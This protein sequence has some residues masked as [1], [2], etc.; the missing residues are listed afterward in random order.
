MS[1]RHPFSSRY[2]EEILRISYLGR[3]LDASGYPQTSP[4]CLVLD[5]R[6]EEFRVLRCEFKYIPSGKGDFERCGQFH[7]AVLCRIPSTTTKEELEKELLAQNGCHETVVLSE[8]KALSELPKY[9]KPEPEE[10]SKVDELRSI[11]LK[12]EY[13][14]VFAA[15]IAASIHPGTFHIDVMVD[16][17]S[18][19]F[20]QVKRM[21]P[22]GRAN[23]V[24]PLMQTKPPLLRHMHGKLYCWTDDINAK[25]AAAEIGR[26][27]RTYFCKDLPRRDIIEEVKRASSY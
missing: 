16:R 7:I 24:S 3:V 4:D 6:G 23:V 25:R 2:G 18:S 27:I 12:S 20:P 5:K 26:M 21:Q 8:H 15:F 17:L 1:L 10:F 22:R 13:P 14:T 19:R 9:H 11:I